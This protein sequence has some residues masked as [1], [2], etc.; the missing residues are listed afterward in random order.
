MVSTDPS[1]D[2]QGRFLTALERIGYEIDRV[3]F[4]EIFVSMPPGRFPPT[5]A[6]RTAGDRNRGLVSMAPRIA[7]LAGLLSNHKDSQLMVVSHAYELFMPLQDLASRVNGSGG[8]VGLAY[9]GTLLDHRYRQTGIIESGIADG[10]EFFDLDPHISELTSGA[11][12]MKSEKSASASGTVFS[13]F[14]L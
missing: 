7:Y 14:R 4:R 9:F 13:K 10:V 3:N 5:I 6:E 12:M 1:S 2:A 8:H 11:V